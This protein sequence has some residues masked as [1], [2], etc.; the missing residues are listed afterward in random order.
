MSKR[1]SDLNPNS[2]KW[3][4]QMIQI[5][6]QHP[7]N[8]KQGDMIKGYQEMAKINLELSELYFEAEREVECFFDQIAECE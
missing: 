2:S 8:N 4:A 5:L 1:S 6:L 7:R 3:I